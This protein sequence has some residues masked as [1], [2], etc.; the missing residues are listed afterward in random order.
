MKA[1]KVLF[2]TLLLFCILSASAQSVS[3]REA[4]NKI[5]GY[6]KKMAYWRQQHREDNIDSVYFYND[7][8]RIYLTD[9][10]NNDF[11]LTSPFP[12]LKKAGMKISTS[13][14]HMCRTYVWEVCSSAAMHYKASLLV[15]KTGA[16]IV[17]IIHRE[18]MTTGNIHTI[19]TANGQTVYLILVENKYGLKDRSCG[20]A[21]YTIDN[22]FLTDKAFFY[23]GNDSQA[24]AGY[25]YDIA[26]YKVHDD[27]LPPTSLTTDKQRVSI[28][29]VKEGGV[30]KG[31]NMIYKFDGNKFVYEKLEKQ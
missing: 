4:E 19:H 12:M 17:G 18:G 25:R 6:L 11:M 27:K 3:P 22:S 10:Q 16:D 15:Y 24:Y 1:N 21:A 26:S 29:I 31:Q 20:F 7:Q 30:Y 14:D 8:L 9:I 23:M 5:S 13:D 2:S 28:P